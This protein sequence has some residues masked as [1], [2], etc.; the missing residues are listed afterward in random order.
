MHLPNGAARPLCALAIPVLAV[1]AITALSGCGSLDVTN[2][3]AIETPALANPTYIPLMVNGTIGEFQPSFGVDAY[4]TA[5]FSDELRNHAVYFEEGLIDQRMVDQ[6]NG[7]YV[8]GVYNGLHQTRFLADSITS[9]LKTLLGDSAK[10]DLGLARV[11]AYAGYTYTLLGEQLCQT[12]LNG[13]PKRYMPKDL[14]RD[15]ALPR[16]QEAITIATA[17]RAAA[18]AI[19]PATTASKAAV[20]GADSVKDFALVGAA[21]T[22]LDLGD[23]AKAVQYASQVTPGFVFSAYYST[24]SS[25]ENNYFYGRVVAATNASVIGTPFE[26]IKD[27]RAPSAPRV[28]SKTVTYLVPNSP[29]TFSTWSGTLPG[30]PIDRSS[31]IRIASYLEAQYVL[32]EAQGPTGANVAFINSRRAVGGTAPLA[33]TVGAADFFTA[34]RDQRKLDFYLDTHR[35]GDLR[36]YKDVYGIDE[37]QKGAYPSGTGSYGDQTCFPESASEIINNPGK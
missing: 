27:P 29:S 15:F 21:R 10:R 37:F 22:A 11:T 25:G 32:A 4:Y 8:G 28:I 33:A 3:G 14:F 30:V 17:A 12:A 9:R 36:R 19:T 34:L 31:N 13:Q 5:L 7:T 18:A 35:L 24:N 20:L 26:T 6:D 2:P 1:A 23:K 16:F